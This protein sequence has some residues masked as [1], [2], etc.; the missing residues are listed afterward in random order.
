MNTIEQLIKQNNLNA[1]RA[2]GRGKTS[3]GNLGPQWKNQNNPLG[4]SEEQLKLL[5]TIINVK[6]TTAPH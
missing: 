6:P 5:N 3:S 1:E 4:L 2:L